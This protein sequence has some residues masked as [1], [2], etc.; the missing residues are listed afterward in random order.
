MLNI[1]SIEA[2]KTINED[3]IAG[4]LN[5]FLNKSL[6]HLGLESKDV[7]RS[8]YT[9]TLSITVAE[10]QVTVKMDIYSPVLRI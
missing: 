8:P 6:L 3:T 2:T 5:A 7:G 9:G 4:P 10:T 1:S